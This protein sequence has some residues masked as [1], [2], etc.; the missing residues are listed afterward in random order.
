LICPS[1]SRGTAAPSFPAE[2]PEPEKK[3]RRQP[4]FAQMIHAALAY[5]ISHLDRQ[6]KKLIRRY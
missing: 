1:R 2:K 5:A 4:E 6:R 3:K